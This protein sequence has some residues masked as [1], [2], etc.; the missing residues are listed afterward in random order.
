[1]GAIREIKDH[2]DAS[3]RSIESRTEAMN[4]KK[5]RDTENVYFINSLI[6]YEEILNHLKFE[7]K[8]EVEKFKDESTLIIWLFSSSFIVLSLIVWYPM[9]KHFFLNERNILNKTVILVPLSIMLKNR[10]LKMYLLK[11]TGDELKHLKNLD[12]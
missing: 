1:M 6:A 12:F 8:S 10:I 9:W 11:K 7:I 3:D 5:F 4:L 2:Y